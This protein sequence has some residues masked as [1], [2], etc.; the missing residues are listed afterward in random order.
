[1]KCPPPNCPVI[2]STR[3]FIT[4]ISH[5][6]DGTSMFKLVWFHS[7]NKIQ[8]L[9][10][11]SQILKL[12]SSPLTTLLPVFPAQVGLVVIA[13]AREP[14]L[15]ST[16][17]IPHTPSPFLCFSGIGEEKKERGIVM[18]ADVTHAHES[19]GSLWIGA[20]LYRLHGRELA[21]SSFHGFWWLL[22]KLSYIF[23]LMPQL[24]SH[25]SPLLHPVLWLRLLL[26]S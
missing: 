15:V 23:P 8:L 25:H 13:A 24:V 22:L 12:S 2:A 20:N 16:L 11:Y 19:V 18:T 9:K 6:V 1:M 10:V 21:S 5:W 7:F 4:H 14:D 26:P 3:I 17:S